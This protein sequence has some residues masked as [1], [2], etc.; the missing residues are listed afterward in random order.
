LKNFEFSTLACSKGKSKFGF[1]IVTRIYEK[2]V[3]PF[4][5]VGGNHQ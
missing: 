3:M 4:G 5:V 1:I 2:N